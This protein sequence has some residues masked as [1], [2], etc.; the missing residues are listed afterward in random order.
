VIT[1]LFQ[2]S[3]TAAAVA[4]CFVLQ[5]T[6]AVADS[7]VLN[8]LYPELT[9]AMRAH[10][11]VFAR[12]L[13]EIDVT[14]SSPTSAIGKQLLKDS[15]VELSEASASHYHSSGGHLAM[16][17]PF[18]VFESRA[19]PSLISTI[20]KQ[21]DPEQPELTLADLSSLTPRAVATLD[22]GREFIE[23]VIAIHVD[24]GYPDKK[25]AVADA[26]K[27]YLSDD[28]T[29]VSPR[30]KSADLLSEHPY[31]YAYSA[32][33]PQFSGLNWASQWLKLATLEI[34]ITSPDRESETRDL[35]NALSLYEDKTTRLHGSLVS[36]PSDIP[37]IP[38]IAPNFYTV[39]PEASSIIDNL[40][41]LKVVIA[42]ILS[43]PDE[44]D[45][46]AAI[47]TMVGKYT[48]KNSDIIK[49]T[50]YMLFVLRGGIYNAGGPA[51]GGMDQPDRNYSREVQEN[52][53][54]SK[55]PMAK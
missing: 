5:S 39:H 51:R 29:S 3:M 43:H 15:L 35:E 55:Y 40:E 7:S 45:R 8:F 33:F 25:A 42:D 36:L 22:R 50:D 46:K 53:H 52:P 23:E 32:G 54:V 12:V 13:E 28:E 18:R 27:V 30:P 48:D 10:D 14:N 20:R 49:P 21:H 17:G 19:T 34:I 9:N 4:S 47:D 31:A 24:D 37:A 26:I 41:A 11:V 16:L 6:S 2:R 1:T 44:F 38:S